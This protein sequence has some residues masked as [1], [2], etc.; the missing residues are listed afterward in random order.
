MQPIVVTRDSYHALGAWKDNSVIAEMC[1]EVL[2]QPLSHI[3]TA[4]I[5]L[6]CSPR[7]GT[8]W[9][10]VGKACM[11]QMCTTPPVFAPT[12]IRSNTTLHDTIFSTMQ[13]A[14]HAVTG[15]LWPPG[16]CQHP[17]YLIGWWGGCSQ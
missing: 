4:T 5:E 8:A 2:L 15:S 6:S 1:S 9:V 11:G 16:V 10:V 14:E 12:A 17:L 13:Q 3:G 7:P